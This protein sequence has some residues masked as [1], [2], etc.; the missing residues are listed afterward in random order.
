MWVFSSPTRPL[1][2]KVVSRTFYKGENGLVLRK[3]KNT[4]RQPV[5]REETHLLIS[6]LSFTIS[7]CHSHASAQHPGPSPALPSIIPQSLWE[8][9]AQPSGLPEDATHA[10][11]AVLTGKE[12]PTLTKN[13]ELGLDKPKRHF[14]LSFFPIILN[15]NVFYEKFNPYVSD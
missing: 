15:L 2:R 3:E 10:L 8:T 5:W 6:K 4:T 7:S 9:G 1:C 14:A 11:S 12:F 13:L